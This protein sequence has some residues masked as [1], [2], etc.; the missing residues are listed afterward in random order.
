[1][2]ICPGIIAKIIITVAVIS[3]LLSAMVEDLKE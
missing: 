3:S 1:M 2:W